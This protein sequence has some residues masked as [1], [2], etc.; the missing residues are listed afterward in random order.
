VST[1]HFDRGDIV[2]VSLNPVIGRKLQ[3]EIRPALVLSTRAFNALGTA[4]VA[5][6]TQGGNLSRF[7][8]FA[9]PLQG[10]GTETQGGAG[11]CR[12]H[13]GLAKGAAQKRLKPPQ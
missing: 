7:A 8:G 2:R 4:L 9:V 5:S 3:G 6:I 13:L 12:P 1:R 10:A 11:E